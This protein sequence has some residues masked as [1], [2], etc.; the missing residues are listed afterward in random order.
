MKLNR[1]NIE[2]TMWEDEDDDDYDDPKT[3][4]TE[5]A[6][7]KGIY[8]FFSEADRIIKELEKRVEFLEFKLNHKGL[9]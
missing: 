5:V 6:D 1:F 8:C 7:S 3:V 9:I 2:A 4:L